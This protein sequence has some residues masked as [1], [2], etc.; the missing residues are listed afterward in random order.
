MDSLER[1]T[2]IAAGASV[3]DACCGPGRHSIELA[4]RGYRVTGVDITETYLEAARESATGL[5]LALEFFKADI[6]NLRPP[7]LLRSGDQ[8]VH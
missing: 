5:G 3:L 8:P 7:R 6:R 4:S 2:E 1:L